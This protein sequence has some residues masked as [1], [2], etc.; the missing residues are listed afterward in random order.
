[1][2]LH[3]VPYVCVPR[4]V[5]GVYSMDRFLVHRGG[6]ETTAVRDLVHHLQVVSTKKGMSRR[7]AGNLKPWKDWDHKKR[8][9]AA[10][11]NA[12]TVGKLS[13]TLWVSCLVCVLRRKSKIVTNQTRMV[14]FNFLT[15]QTSQELWLA[16][17]LYSVPFG[18]LPFVAG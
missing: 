17:L 3:L 11:L 5:F 15:I 2:V 7:A 13:S 6:T 14:K 1:M 12:P 9:N 8:K 18:N 10:T 16:A 4:D